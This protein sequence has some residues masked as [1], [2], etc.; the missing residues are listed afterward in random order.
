MATPTA[1]AATPTATAHIGGG[2]P[3]RAAGTRGAPAG[4]S[5]FFNSL[6]LSSSPSLGLGL[7]L[8]GSFGSFAFFLASCFFL[9]SSSCA[10]TVLFHEEVAVY[11]AAFI[12]SSTYAASTCS[13]SPPLSKCHLKYFLLYASE[14]FANSAFSQSVETLL[15]AN[16][17]F[18][19]V[20]SAGSYI[21][22]KI[23][24]TTVPVLHPG[25]QLS[26]WKLDIDRQSL[27]LV[28]KRPLGVS[29][30]ISGGFIG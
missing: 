2:T 25:S 24:N 7:L 9:A 5:S 19:K 15:P 12:R 6:L 28:S 21:N 23:P 20:L 10:K 11:P 29:I 30:W 18:P 8:A 13:K 3:P 14:F 26:G 17:I 16:G 1:R 22:D 4:L 27:V